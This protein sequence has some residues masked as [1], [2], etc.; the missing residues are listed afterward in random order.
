MVNGPAQPAGLGIGGMRVS[1]TNNVGIT[2][3]NLTSAT[4]LTPTA[5]TYYVANFQM[6][7]DAPGNSI[8]QGVNLVADQIAVLANFQSNAMANLGLVS[9]T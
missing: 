8:L 9:R 6:P 3:V 7:I 5:G 1:S 2:F 4:A